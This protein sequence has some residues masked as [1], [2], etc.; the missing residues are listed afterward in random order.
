MLCRSWA[1][2]CLQI[3]L[4]VHL[5][6][7]TKLKSCKNELLHSTSKT[8]AYIGPFTV[9][10]DYVKAFVEA[11]LQHEGNAITFQV[12]IYFQDCANNMQKKTW[13]F[14]FLCPT[15]HLRHTTLFLPPTHISSRGNRVS[16][17]FICM[18]VC[19]CVCHSGLSQPNCLTHGHEV[20]HKWFSCR[21]ILR[22]KYVNAWAF[23]C[24][25]ARTV[26]MTT[27]IF[28]MCSRTYKACHIIATQ[29]L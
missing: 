16:P 15:F 20:C 25:T 27:Y 22:W 10:H 11:T 21:A 29:R 12:T 3:D 14:A 2:K 18:S 9:C 6:E 4:P 13:H 23:S 28:V 7:C 1:F 5:L 19:V 17:V 8:L 24:S 26:L